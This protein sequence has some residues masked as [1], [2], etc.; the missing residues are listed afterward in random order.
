[1]SPDYIVLAITVAAWFTCLACVIHS[2]HK[3]GGL[4]PETL[5]QF[6]IFIGAGFLLLS[7]LAAILADRYPFFDYSFIA[8]KPLRPGI[9]R[10]GIIVAGLFFLF[11]RE[12]K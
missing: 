12:K 6:I 1:M 3:H 11:W 2:Q 9:Y 5:N 8:D 4:S 10:S 7:D